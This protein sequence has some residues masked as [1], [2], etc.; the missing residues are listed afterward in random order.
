MERLFCYGT[1]QRRDVQVAAFGRE[2]IGH[3]D[4]LSGFRRTRVPIRDPEAAAQLGET[5][6]YN[7]EPG[8]ETNEE[9]P[10]TVLELTSD[11]LAAADRYE[12]D[13]DYRRIPVTLRSGLESWVYLIRAAD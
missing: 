8:S 7:L 1:L 12:E 4:A 2:L 5:H 10:G 3:P 13:A 11:E 9:V 6:Y